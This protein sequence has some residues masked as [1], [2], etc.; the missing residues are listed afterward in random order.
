MGQWLYKNPGRCRRHMALLRQLVDIARDLGIVVEGLD[1]SDL[2]TEVEDSHCTV[3]L[4]CTCSLVRDDLSWG[5]TLR[6]NG[7]RA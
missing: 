5:G 6:V 3:L 2:E 7:M 1:R 4:D